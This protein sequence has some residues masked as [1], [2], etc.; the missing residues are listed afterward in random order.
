MANSQQFD[1]SAEIRPRYENK[2]GY[3][4]LIDK[5]A[6]GTNF[7]S[8]RTRLNFDYKNEK[9]KIGLVMQNARVWGDVSTLSN[10][11]D[12]FSFHEA[13]AEAILNN[14]ISLKLGR[15]EIVYDDQR[16]FGNVGW[17]QQARSHD[18]FLLK[19]NPSLNHNINLGLALNADSQ[20]AVDNL[21]SNVAGYKEFQYARYYGKFNKINISFLFLNTGVEYLTNTELP[22][23]GKSIDYTQTYGSRLMYKSNGFNA[24]ISGYLQTGKTHNTNVKASYFSLNASYNLNKRINLGIGAEYIS[25]KDQNDLSTDNKSFSPLFGTNHK[26]NGWMDYFYVSNHNNSVGLTDVYGTLQYDK[27][28]FSVKVMPHLFSSAAHVHNSNKM[29]SYLGTEIDLSVNYKASKKLTFSTGYSKMFATETMKT[30]K[31]TGDNN[32]NN[33]WVWIMFTFKP[34]LF[35]HTNN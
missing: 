4:I 22:N 8:Q 17:A 29:N 5:N 12:A 18:A 34:M 2:H 14:K 15:Q 19:Y 16:I 35:S 23:G 28:K 20:S 3:G 30:L 27:N 24:N 21:Y 32:A 1:L 6:G 26:F 11:D 10:N 25:G 9:I 7:I 33:S 31:G 13:W